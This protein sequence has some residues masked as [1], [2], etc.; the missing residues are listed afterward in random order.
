MNSYSLGIDIGTTSICALARETETGKTLLSLNKSNTA[1]VASE[2]SFEK[3]Q[4]PSVIISVAFGLIKEA[5]QRLGNPK[6]IG[7]TG[8]MHGILYVDGNGE[9]V[10]P[11]Y[12]WQDARAAQPL[13][14]SET[15][16]EYIT[17]MTSHK[18]FA[19]YGM[20]THFY[21]FKNGKI[22][23]G[24]VKLCTIHDYLAMT[25][26]GLREPIMHV[27]DA[28]SLGLYDPASN[29]FDTD[30][31]QILGFSADIFPKVTAKSSP[32]GY[33]RGS[34]PV[35][36]AI[37]DNQASFL[38]SAGEQEGVLLVNVGTGSQV[39]VVGHFG[40]TREGIECRPFVDGKYLL[41]GSSL[42]GGRAYAVLEKCFRDIANMCGAD[43][44][45][46]Y[47]FMD[48]WI[49]GHDCD[50]SLTVSTLFDGTRQEP[51]LRGSITGISVTNFDPVSLMVGFMR[52]I[53]CELYGL[54][55]SMNDLVSGND[56][57][58]LVGSGNGLR[59]NPAL[60]RIIEDVFGMPL[61]LSDS[62]EEAALGAAVFA[63]GP[64]PV[65]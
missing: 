53:A 26:A 17:R 49:E 33:Y 36:P 10:S 35:Y 28:A 25:L 12:T 60:C 65:R 45:S 30:A 29:S 56:I 31:A 19:G 20:A 27:S 7:I 24:A 14:D 13:N 6:S 62:K 4:D 39:S 58:A 32:I 41:V 8:Q 51:A 21:Q 42:C 54:F 22:P 3:I 38:G 47:P 50:S 63:D 46:A 52:G 64:Y 34:I 43:I 15:Y 23:N 2:H 40:Q 48:K 59:A 5:E 11:L 16:I 57:K 61:K 9:A 18:I 1:S 37:G 55:E 44:R